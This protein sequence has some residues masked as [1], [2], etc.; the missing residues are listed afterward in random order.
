MH[1]RTPQQ[2]LSN[3][4][5]SHASE[6]TRFC[7]TSP[8]NHRRKPPAATHLD[9][10]T[11]RPLLT[12][13]QARKKPN[14]YVTSQ[15]PSYRILMSGCDVSDVEPFLHTPIEEKCASQFFASW[16]CDA[17]IP[18]FKKCAK[19]EHPSRGFGLGRGREPRLSQLR[20]R[21]RH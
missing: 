2:I 5:Q 8:T 20:L 3:H 19:N 15:V 1:A 4:T 12:M 14:F 10:L 18:Y 17:Q 13:G 9:T 11:S 7:G 21:N 16:T 6:H